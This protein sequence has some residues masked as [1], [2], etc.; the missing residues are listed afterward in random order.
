MDTQKIGTFARKA[1]RL[2]YDHTASGSNKR[3]PYRR[4]GVTPRSN[5]T[6]VGVFRRVK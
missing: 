4:A 3:K 2:V 6:C 5:A 1:G